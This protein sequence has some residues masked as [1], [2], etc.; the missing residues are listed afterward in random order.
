MRLYEHEGAWSQ[1]LAG[2]DAA[3]RRSE[4]E[5]AIVVGGD[6][7]RAR[8]VDTL[9]RMGCL[10]VLDVYVRSLPAEEAAA[11]EI[12]EARF[13]AAWRAGRWD[14]PA[15]D[16]AAAA[17]A[18]RVDADPDAGFHRGLHAALATLR[19]GN[20]AAASAGL[21][22]IRG[23]LVRRATAEGAEAEETAR[24]AVVRLR[25]LDDVADAARLWNAFRPGGGGAGGG[26][27]DSAEAALDPARDARA[28]GSRRRRRRASATRGDGVARS[29]VDRT[30]SPSHF[31]RFTAGFCE[32]SGRGGARR[33]SRGDGV[34]GAK[35]RG[36]GRGPARD[37]PGAC[38]RRRRGRE[39]AR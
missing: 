23:S 17:A 39:V 38:A 6:E 18:A 27:R 37:P 1:A 14:L 36:G 7:A 8:L 10:H 28:R 21:D 2:H 19:A 4:G 30:V 25:M 29:G 32:K 22:A 15:E 33:A 31:W 16:A 20:V 35:S 12:A 13:E 26:A 11:P 34:V 3:L 5:R 9:R 24:A